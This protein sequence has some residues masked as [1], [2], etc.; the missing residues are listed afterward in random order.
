MQG[1]MYLVQ[2]LQV[3]A[4]PRLVLSSYPGA[5]SSEG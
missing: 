1:E 3:C 4:I 5:A 2:H